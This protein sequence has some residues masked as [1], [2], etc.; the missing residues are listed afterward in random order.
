MDKVYKKFGEVF[1]NK[2]GLETDFAKRLQRETNLSDSVLLIFAFL[3]LAL[4]F[5]FN[6]L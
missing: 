6:S 4:V 5:S 2:F 3:L 1:E